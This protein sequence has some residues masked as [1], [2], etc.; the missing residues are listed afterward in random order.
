MVDELHDGIYLLGR[1]GPVGCGAWLFVSDKECALFEAPEYGR[2]ET[3]PAE[4]ARTIIDVNGLALRY[5]LI[6]HPHK[7]HVESLGEYRSRFPGATFIAH[8]TASYIRNGSCTGRLVTEPNL[9]RE[10]AVSDAMFDTLYEDSVELPL[11]SDWI[12]QVHAPKHSPGDTVTWFHQ[13]LFTGDWWLYEGDPGNCRE[14][15]VA[16]NDSIRRLF[17]Y[18]EAHRLP[19]QHVFPSH[20]NNLLYHI[21]IRDVL[22]RSLNLPGMA[23]A[24]WCEERAG[25]Y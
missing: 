8:K 6:S 20:A 24:R 11:G 7:D 16:A 4:L 14:V 9:W 22:G 19:V 13:A 18:L 23:A 2:G 15:Q 1:F 12:H 10:V 5:V 25:D 17:D 3:S 21:D